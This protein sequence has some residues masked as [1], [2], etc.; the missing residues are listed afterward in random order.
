MARRKYTKYDKKTLNTVVTI[1][2]F[3]F[4]MPIIGIKMLGS[5]SVVSKVI[6]GI[7]VVLGVIVWI[8]LA[9]G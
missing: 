4:G 1:M 7:L 2:L 9:T 5:E 6:G 3:V 8:K